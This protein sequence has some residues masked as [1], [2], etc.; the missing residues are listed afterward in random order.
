MQ[1]AD[2]GR[3]NGTM[4]SRANARDGLMGLLSRARQHKP[5]QTYPIYSCAPMLPISHQPLTFC[6][7]AC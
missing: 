1:T 3:A 5:S 6:R 4:Y 7:N 2:E